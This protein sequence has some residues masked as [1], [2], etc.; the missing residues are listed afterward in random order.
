MKLIF[1][2]LV[3]L[4][5]FYMVW[6]NFLRAPSSSASRYQVPAL[7][8][9]LPSLKLLSEMGNLQILADGVEEDDSAGLASTS[10]AVSSIGSVDQGVSPVLAQSASRRCDMIGPFKSKKKAQKLRVQL[11]SMVNAESRIHHKRIP[12][13]PGYWV[14]L[15]PSATRAKALDKL[16][17][18]QSR[19]V[20]SY[21]IPKGDLVNG[22]SL[23]MF[24]QKSL[25][26]TRFRELKA[27]GLS[28]K[29]EIIERAYRE[30]WTMLEPG[31]EQK[32]TDV[33]WDQLLDEKNKL[34][35]QQNFC[36]DVAK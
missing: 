24:S 23:G 10:Q 31:E 28:P 5:I 19:G 36:L 30:Y 6:A 22:I 34:E 21:V 12:A 20:D 11:A 4:N 2:F 13:G 32:M 16:S 29:I 7:P 35:R 14:Y 9:H 15:E 1:F 25:S 27:M 3:G 18:L 26:D 33:V 8:N 17:D